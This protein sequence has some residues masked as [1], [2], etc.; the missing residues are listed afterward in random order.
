MSC[1]LLFELQFNSQA[2]EISFTIDLVRFLY[3]L[4][5]LNPVNIP[6]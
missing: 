4:T 6:I 1:C 2:C 3:K 5:N